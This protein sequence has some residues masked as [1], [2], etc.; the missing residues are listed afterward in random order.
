MDLQSFSHILP[1][2]VKKKKGAETCYT[3]CP[4][5]PVADMRVPCRRGGDWDGWKTRWLLRSPTGGPRPCAWKTKNW[6]AFASVGVRTHHL[7]ATDPGWNHW[8]GLLWLLERMR[9]A[10][11]SIPLRNGSEILLQAGDER[12]EHGVRRRSPAQMEQPKALQLA[13][14]AWRKGVRS[15]AQGGAKACSPSRSKVQYQSTDSGCDPRRTAA[16]GGGLGA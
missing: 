2:F 12:T 15:R 11:Y 13:A 7:R 10:F 5:N 14:V 1:F 9:I 3:R 6:E 8:A 4:L 16:T